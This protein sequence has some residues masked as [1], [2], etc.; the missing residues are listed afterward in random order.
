MFLAISSATC[1]LFPLSVVKLLSF[2]CITH[3]ICAGRIRL[4]WRSTCIS[5]YPYV[6]KSMSHLCR[7]I[8]FDGVDSTPNIGTTTGSSNSL[9]IINIFKYLIGT[10]LDAKH[11]NRI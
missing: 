7:M 11:R 6:A 3:F 4:K 2:Y 1:K 10:L 5:D 8:N 9:C